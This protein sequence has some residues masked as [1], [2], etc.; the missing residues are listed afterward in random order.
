RGIEMQIIY[1]DRPEQ[2]PFLYWGVRVGGKARR[3]YEGGTLDEGISIGSEGMMRNYFS[4]G[5]QLDYL[6]R[7]P[8]IDRTIAFL[9][10]WNTLD[11]YRN[12][13]FYTMTGEQNGGRS[14]YLALQQKLELAPRL[15]LGID[16]EQLHIDYPD[17]PDDDRSRQ[18]IVTLNYEITP[19]RAI[20]GRLVVNRIESGGEVSTT[21]NFYL[22]YLQRVRRGFDL[23]IIYGLPNASRTQNR[24]AVKIVTP[25]E[26]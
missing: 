17:T 6:R 21:R 24:F 22:T 1:T 18:A 25:I 11:L 20:G 16:L 26:W 15:R 12:G 9:V 19:E 7:P 23:Y 8:N 5:V 2:G 10:R 14:L 13:A 4:L 3:L